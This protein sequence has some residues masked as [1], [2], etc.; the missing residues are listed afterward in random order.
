MR[1]SLSPRTFGLKLPPPLL[2]LLPIGA[3]L[4]ALDRVAI[5]IGNEVVVQVTKSLIK[6]VPRLRSSLFQGSGSSS[7][8]LD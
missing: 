5:A 3:L 2:P 8:E 1:F 7:V 6:R 4:F